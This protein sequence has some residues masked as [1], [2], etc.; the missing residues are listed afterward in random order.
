MAIPP[1]A[2]DPAG[3]LSI[4]AYRVHLLSRVAATLGLQVQVVAVGWQ[5]YALTGSAL[6]LGLVG[7]VQFLPSVV[8]LFAV[9]V[10]LDRGDRRRILAT[11][12]FAQAAATLT[13]A[14]VSASGWIGCE[15][16]FVFVA[17]LGAT[18]AFELPA[19]QAILP[20]LVPPAMLS[21]AV[22]LG[23]SA[24]QAATIVGPEVTYAVA[25]GLYLIG[26]AMALWLPKSVHGDGPPARVTREYL[27]AG[28]G[29]IR[30]RP[31]L[32]G[33]ISLDM[34][35]VLLGGATALLPI[36]AKDILQ[37][38][39]WGLGLLRSAPAVGALGVAL[40]L[41][42]R[43]L[44]RRVGPLL[45]AA[46]AVFG[47]AT[48]VFGLSTSLPLSFVALAVLGGADMVSVVIRMSIV[49]LETPDAMRGRVGAVNSVFIGASNQ[50]GEF[51]SGVAAAWLGPVAAVVLGGLGT[52]AVVGIWMRLFPALARRDRLEPSTDDGEG[53]VRNG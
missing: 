37:T 3:P 28:V 2:A 45:F 16:L 48:V 25:G 51:E 34:V 50:I 12:R 8:L 9:G 19:T 53:P 35:A 1:V 31:V 47:A 13:L 20:S 27:F 21:R 7:L 18:R 49:Q 15:A 40:W 22:A 30:S 39:P 52:L 11:A 5:M 10:I 44:Q 23:S 32:L 41:S 33:A 24:M 29:F 36:Y 38:G 42:R 46:V 14:V 43:P 26:A 6:D 17:V 4:P